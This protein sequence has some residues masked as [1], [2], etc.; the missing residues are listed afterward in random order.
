MAFLK[1]SRA[2][3]QSQAAQIPA[4]HP[5]DSESRPERQLCSQTLTTD[6]ASGETPQ[7]PPALSLSTEPLTLECTSRQQ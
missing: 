6:P 4:N 5:L 2:N 1:S 3:P 7:D